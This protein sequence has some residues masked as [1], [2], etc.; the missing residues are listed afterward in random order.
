MSDEEKTT[1]SLPTT[2]RQLLKY[3]AAGSVGGLATFGATQDLRSQNKTDEMPEPPSGDS[4]VYDAFV[5][6]RMDGYEAIGTTGETIDSGTDGWAVLKNSIAAVPDGG[7]MY[8]SGH[9]TSSST[10]DVAKSIGVDAREA[11]VDQQQAGRFVFRFGGEER[12][13]T[14]LSTTVETGD[15]TLELSDSSAQRGDLLLFRQTD[16]E[17]VLGRRHYPS[18]SHSVRAASGT[19]VDLSDSIVWRDGYDQGT[20]VYV[21]DPVKVR[22]AGMSLRAPAKDQNYY[23]IEVTNCRDSIINGL[24]LEK[25]GSRALL[26]GSC[27]NSRVRDCTVHESADIKAAD[28]YGIQVWSG[29]HNILVEGCTATE[30]RHPLS[31]TAGGNRQVASRAIIFRDCFVSGNGAGALNCHGGSAHDVRFE[32]CTVHTQGDPGLTTGAQQTN[33]TGCEFRM[34]GHNAIG[35]RGDGQ[36]G[37]ITVSDTD[38]YNATNAVKISRETDLKFAPLWKFVHLDG[39]RAHDCNQFFTLATGEIDRVRDLVIE[40]CYWDR[41]SEEGIRLWNQ[42]DGGIIEGND[43]GR[44]TDSPHVLIRGKSDNRIENLRI[45]G[46]QF[47][48]SAGTSEFIRLVNAEQCVVSNNTFNSK[49]SVNIYVGAADSTGNMI[50][51]NTYYAPDPPADPIL[52]N[53]GSIVTGNKIY[54]TVSARWQ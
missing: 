34:D 4:G 40:G 35:T 39:V 52:E 44:T 26:V 20:T 30:C 11:S 29:C 32:G 22:L 1:E 49:S 51:Q 25:F 47:G 53:D 38:V 2:R 9:Y 15:K 13:Q 8:V 42:V 36:E 33:V 28:G 46:N 50:A 23:G 5:R 54:D 24:T 16:A 43:F 10:I 27:A 3:V 18:E 31:V 7:S 21:I 14:T 17:P 37:I 41:V 6:E 45:T 48:E 12:Q 19:T